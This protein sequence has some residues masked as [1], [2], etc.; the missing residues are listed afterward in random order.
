MTSLKR[1]LC[2]S[3]ALALTLSTLAI[4]TNAAAQANAPRVR[5]TIAE[6]PMDRALEQLAR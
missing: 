3:A 4:A 2:R 1:Q 6:Q 5:V